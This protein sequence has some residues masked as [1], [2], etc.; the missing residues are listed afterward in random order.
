[1]SRLRSLRAPL[2]AAVLG[3][4][5][6]LLSALVISAPARAVDSLSND[7][8]KTRAIYYLAMSQPQERDVMIGTLTAR[9][10]REGR[11]WSNFLSTWASINTSMA[12]HTKVPTGLPTKGHVFVVL[13]SGL[14]KSGAV[15]ATFQRRLALAAKAAKAYPASTI[16]IT[17]GAPRN[18]RTEAEA[19][20]RWLRKAG[21]K[22]SRMLRETRASSTIGNA[23]YSMAMLARNPRY[24]TYSLISD[25]SHLRRASVLFEAAKVLVQE[26]SGKSW[27]ITRLANVAYPDLPRA[28]Q[29]PL[30]TSSVKIAADNVASLFSLLA[31]YRRLVAKAPAKPTLTSL[32][33]TPPTAVR[34]QVGQ[35]LNRRGLVV[36]ALY[37]DGVYTRVITSTAT[38]TGFDTRTV[39]ARRAT[40]SYTYRGLTRTARFDYHVVKSGSRATAKASTT[41]ATR[42]RTRVVLTVTVKPRVTGVQPT[43]RVRFYL[44]GARVATV[45]LSAAKPGVASF[46]YGTIA[47]IGSHRLVAAYQGDARVAASSAG[48]TVTVRK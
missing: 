21:V 7:S 31:P 19:G 38:I 10:S 36:R 14:K 15:S 37:D 28:G 3:A 40:L 48:V 2:V 25:S 4:T 41:S 24:T 6:S 9:T 33:L 1:M 29:V 32:R 23:E 34:Y 20:Y 46:R 35:A 13:G 42:S 5:L 22:A 47:A 17:G 11:L 39:G 43:G 26:R 18:G 8:L 45:P 12:M 30:R 44:D 16:L 27:G